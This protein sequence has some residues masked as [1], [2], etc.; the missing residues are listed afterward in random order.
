MNVK[1]AVENKS[2]LIPYGD[3]QILVAPNRWKKVRQGFKFFDDP[4]RPTR[5]NYWVYDGEDNLVGVNLQMTYL[6]TPEQALQEAKML[7][8][9]IIEN[10]A[11]WIPNWSL[12]K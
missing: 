10:K 12:H 9:E 5:Y 2:K 11:S 4:T 7:V 8:Q 3:H 1:V 6:G